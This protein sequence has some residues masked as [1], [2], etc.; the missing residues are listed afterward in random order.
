MLQ[1]NSGQHIHSVASGR[2]TH[3]R[4][5]FKT[6]L[7]PS[8]FS[9]SYEMSTSHTPIHHHTRKF[10]LT[11]RITGALISGS[12]VLS[13]LKP[14]SNWNPNDFDIYVPLGYH[15]ILIKLFELDGFV[16]T[17][18]QQYPSSA[19]STA[20]EPSYAGSGIAFIIKMVKDKLIV[21][22][23]VSQQGHLPF[24]CIAKFHST[25]IM[26]FISVDGLFSA[27]PSLTNAGILMASK[28]PHA[29]DP[30]QPTAKLIV[31]YNKY[32]ERG[33]KI[34]NIP[35]IPGLA[36]LFP[37]VKPNLPHN[38]KHSYSCPQTLWSTFDDGCMFFPLSHNR[39]TEVLQPGFPSHGLYRQERGVAWCI[40]GEHCD[41]N[42][43][44]LCPFVSW[45]TDNVS[46]ILLL[47]HRL[48]VMHHVP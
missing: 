14:R 20:I 40:G 21:D 8:K 28:I 9:H 3:V 25:A 6:P 1:W 7:H 13:I 30:N 43:P 4:S 26:N 33:Y 41:G 5:N 38:C 36:N 31:A 46:L 18:G 17:G 44:T 35:N 47:W 39:R 15:F 10:L 19:F 22:V 2:P 16:V 45:K 27:Y 29:S 32:Q 12:S 37:N 42:S 11:M 34:C 48:L 24:Y 23:V